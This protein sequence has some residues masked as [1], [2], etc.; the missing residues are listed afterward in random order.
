MQR[1]GDG[2]FHLFLPKRVGREETLCTSLCGEQS[3]LV[4]IDSHS[5]IKR[6][7]GPSDDFA[8]QAYNIEVRAYG[9]LGDHPRIASLREVTDDGIVLERGECLRQKIQSNAS[10]TAMQTKLRWAQEAAEGLRYIHMK[11]II[12]A[13]VGC[14]NL[15][16]DQ[17]GHIKF[18]DFAGSGIDGEV[19]TVCYEWCSYQPGSEP[20]V[21]TDIFAFGSTLYEIETGEK[22]YHE[23]EK[24]L[25][26]GNLMRRVE[27]LFAMGEYPRVDTLVL[28]DV[29]LRCWNGDYSVMDQVVRDLDVLPGA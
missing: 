21:R 10:Q 24:T 16:L 19:A 11:N 25:N 3:I 18:I 14:H 5:V 8:C 4:A 22:P 26:A 15:I 27:Q 17:S 1:G 29:I 13:D 2:S 23:L 7:P 12:H 9:R 20:D 6:R 28:G